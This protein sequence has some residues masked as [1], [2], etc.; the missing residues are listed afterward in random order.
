MSGYSEPLWN[1]FISAAFQDLENA[2]DITKRRPILAH[3]TSIPTLE[4]ILKNDEIWFSNPLYMNDLDE[5]KF[6]IINGIK[7]LKESSAIRDALE[8]DKRHRIFM[9]TIDAHLVN[10][11]EKFLFDTYVFCLS[12]HETDDTDGLLSMWRGYGGYGEGAALIFDTSK[13]DAI[14][15]S[16]LM[17]AKVEYGSNE[18]RIGWFEQLGRTI[19]QVISDSRINDD[20]I[21]LASGAA[22]ERLKLMALFSKHIGFREEKEWRIVYMM[23]R[24]HQEKLSSMQGYI[25]GNYGV[26]PK[27]KFKV[28][29][30][31]GVT[32]PGL[33]LDA[34]IHSIILGPSISSPLATRSF[35]RM[36]E[37]I[38][39]SGLRDRVVA[40][41]I[42][43]RGR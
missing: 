8:T 42:P 43:L 35:L 29:H 23:D 20:S 34:I 41:S 27:L 16:P 2:E 17:F 13:L 25:I 14:E 12:E 11:E 5:I 4:S 39:R 22:F 21:Y 30:I 33:A 1:A 38:D 24:D 6:G 19:A 15:E 7:I 10:Y 26:E 28:G 3:Y 40:S 32:S 31:D 37:K 9:D 18:E 36:L